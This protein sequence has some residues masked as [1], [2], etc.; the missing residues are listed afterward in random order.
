MKK[1]NIYYKNIKKEE[2][3]MNHFNK[4][5][6]IIAIIL[7][8]IIGIG[9][10]CYTDAIENTNEEEIENVLEVAQTNTTKETEE[11][12]IFVHIAGCVQ[13]E[14]MLELSSNSRI[15]DAIEK[16]GGI[17]QEENKSDINLAYLLED[18][19]KIYIPNQNERQEN[20]EKTKNTP[21]EENTPSM[22][23]QD[24][25]TKQDV[26]NINT[27]TQE[28]LDTLPG[29][30]PATATKIIE[31]RKEKGKFKQKEEIKE[32]SGIGEAKYEKIK[33]YISIK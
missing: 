12:N 15:A 25:N 24:T 11:K 18:G 1:F 20:N 14:G 32:V 33:E 8:T 17:T 28:E 3:S 23:I 29:I 2:Q 5:Q 6:K 30:G 13:K 19:M 10:Y 16:A 31:Y 21:K 22:Q 4:K 7:I 27:A 9:I 26:I